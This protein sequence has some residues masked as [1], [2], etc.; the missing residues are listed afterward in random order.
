MF[1]VLKIFI[2]RNLRLFD[3]KTKKIAHKALKFPEDWVTPEAIDSSEK[4]NVQSTGAREG[5]TVPKKKTTTIVNRLF[6]DEFLPTFCRRLC[7]SPRGELLLVPGGLLPPG[8]NASDSFKVVDQDV[9]EQQ[10]NASIDKKPKMKTSNNAV[11]MFCRHSWTNPC[12]VIPT[13]DSYAI[14]TRFCPVYFKKDRRPYV[15]GNL[16]DAKYCKMQ[17][18]NF[19][20]IY[21]R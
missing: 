12:A 13:L 17:I 18:I 5:E 8:S 2:C 20:N 6:Q 19:P 14:G 9:T 21:G 11:I 15:Y 3:L 4:E 7:F 10:E 16:L 1:I